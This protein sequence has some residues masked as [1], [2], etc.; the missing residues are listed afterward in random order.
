MNTYNTSAYEPESVAVAKPIPFSTKEMGYDPIQVD[1][2]LQKLSDEYNSLQQSYTDLFGKYDA[3][4]RQSGVSL[5]AISKAM[6][7]AEVQAMRIVAEA[8]SEA[9]KI[10][11]DAHRDL[12]FIQNEKARLKTEIGGIA[13]RLKSLGLTIPENVLP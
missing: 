3:L 8:K 2:Y 12:T 6:V 13:N 7:N 5:E 4:T 1:Q 9:S 11:Q 10:I